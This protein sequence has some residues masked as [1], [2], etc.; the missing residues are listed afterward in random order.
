[1][2]SFYLFNFKY[3]LQISPGFFFSWKNNLQ[4]NMSNPIKT[5]QMN[6]QSYSL[7]TPSFFHFLF[8]TPQC[9]SAERR[10]DQFSYRTGSFGK[11]FKVKVCFTVQ[12]LWQFACESTKGIMLM[13]IA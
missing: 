13:A 8:T 1:M 11:V 10:V 12:K 3:S 9:A 5:L 4:Y 7:L 6:A 2:F